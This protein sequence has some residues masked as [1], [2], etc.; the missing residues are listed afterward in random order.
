M[1]CTNVLVDGLSKKIQ[2]L[3]FKIERKP[4]LCMSSKKKEIKRMNQI[5]KKI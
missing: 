2:I 1:G 4:F 3:F 5:K